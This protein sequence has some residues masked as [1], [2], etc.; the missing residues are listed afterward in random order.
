MVIRPTSQMP[1]QV[2]RPASASALAAAARGDRFE[3]GADPRLL[4]GATVGGAGA[5]ALVLG[6]GSKYFSGP[7]EVLLGMAN[8][9]V[10]GAAA[11]GAIGAV[12]AT[13]LVQSKDD[14]RSRGSIGAALL[15]G[16]MGSAGGL[17]SGALLGAYVG[18]AAGN[19]LG[20]A[21]GAALGGGAAYLAARH[22]LARG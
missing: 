10:V 6:F 5:G 16:A 11:G 22:R 13:A 17:V 4:V 1:I 20:F 7:T 15:G 3:P 12:V 21:A 9:S 14:G 19:V 18:H 8:G 2:A